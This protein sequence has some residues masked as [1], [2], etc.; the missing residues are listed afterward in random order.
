MSFD[1]SRQQLGGVRGYVE[2]AAVNGGNPLPS[3]EVVVAA[4]DL[5]WAIGIAGWCVGIV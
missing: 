4:F 3:D 5:Y 1:Q 2:G